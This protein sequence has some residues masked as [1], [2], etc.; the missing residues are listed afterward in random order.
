MAQIILP[1]VEVTSDE[2]PCLR[3]KEEDRG[4]LSN[5]KPPTAHSIFPSIRRLTELQNTVVVV[6]DGIGGLRMALEVKERNPSLDV[7]VVGVGSGRIRTQEIGGIRVEAG[8]NCFN[9]WDEAVIGLQDFGVEFVRSQPEER[10]KFT[11]ATGSELLTE[12]QFFGRNPELLRA[13]GEHRSAFLSGHP[14]KLAHRLK[15]MKIDVYL[16]FLIEDCELSKDSVV[17]LGRIIESEWCDLN[18]TYDY[19][20]KNGLAPLCDGRVF[21]DGEAIFR[22]SGG[23]SEILNV[24]SDE[25]RNRGITFI[26]DRVLS[27]QLNSSDDLVV[28]GLERGAALICGRVG[29]AV[30]LTEADKII[31][32]L[33]RERDITGLPERLVRCEL[34][35]AVSQVNKRIALVRG[36]VEENLVVVR[37]GD[38]DSAALQVLTGKARHTP[39]GDVIPLT[40]YGKQGALPQDSA[41]FI[42]IISDYLGYSET[43]LQLLTDIIETSHPPSFVQPTLNVNLPPNVVAIIPDKVYLSTGVD[44]DSNHYVNGVLRTA[45]TT[46]ELLARERR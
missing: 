3:N 46:A 45:V 32:H 1:K 26:E 23:N 31:G 19:F 37:C 24:L 39:D 42:D 30:P 36:D 10:E 2:R 8:A 17:T 40:I 33:E 6:G 28:L 41:G 38:V 25:C 15:S 4:L 43:R 29:L 14:T 5:L 12:E 34:P 44:G 35:I 16:Q 22:C 21:K 13:L 7:L 27:L 18:A 20:A 11:F 9:Q